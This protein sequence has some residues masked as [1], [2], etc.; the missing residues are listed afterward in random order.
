MGNT[1]VHRLNHHNHPGAAAKR[2]VV[3]TPVFVSGI[4][5]QVDDVYLRDALLTC[6]ADD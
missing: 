2:I 4:V 5:A 3:N 6:S 1:I